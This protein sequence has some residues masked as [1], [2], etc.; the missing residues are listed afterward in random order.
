MRHRMARWRAPILLVFLV[1]A[2]LTWSALPAVAAANTPPT[3]ISQAVGVPFNSP[4]LITLTATDADG[5]SAL[6]YAI[7]TNPAHGSLSGLNP[8]TGKVTYTPASGYSGADSFTF[9]A[10]DGADTS[11]PATVQ[12]TV[13]PQPTV[14]H[15]TASLGFGDQPVG[16][17]SPPQPVLLANTSAVPVTIT[18]IAAGGDFTRTTTCLAV[19]DPGASCSINVSFVPT[20]TGVR[21]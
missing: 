13:S 19:L 8:T 18:S 16:T 14:S 11:A 10:N 6:T 5:P 12:I 3:A 2:G 7:A 9:T 15:S 20:T 21:S 17:A 1:M 4:S